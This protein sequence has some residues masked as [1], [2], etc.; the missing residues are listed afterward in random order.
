MNRREFLALA[1]AAAVTTMAKEGAAAAKAAAK[2][3][4]PFFRARP[5]LQLLGEDRFGVV[6]MTS[7][8]A[9]G[10]IEWSQDDGK[11]W[12]KVWTEED[13][14]RDANGQMHRAIVE[15]GYDPRKPLVYRVHSR[16]F[17]EFGGAHV[18]YDG[19]ETVLENRMGAVIRADGSVSFLMVND[20][21]GEAST[22]PKLMD[23]VKEPVSFTVFNGDILDGINNEDQVVRQLLGQMSLV[24]ERTQAACWYLRGNHETR[25]AYARHLRDYLALPDGHFYGATTMGDARIVFIDSG[26]DKADDH[27]EYSGLVDFDHYLQRQRR[28]LEREFASDAWK[29]AGVRIVITHIPPWFAYENNEKM[30]WRNGRAPR[31]DKFFDILNGANVTLLIAGHVHRCTYGDPFTAR[32]RFP[33]YRLFPVVAGGGWDRKAENPLNRPTL[34]RFTVKGKEVTATFVDID[35]KTVFTRTYKA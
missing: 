19:D 4:E 15:E 14:L 32:K 25:G 30:W 6:W 13:G 10:W 7:R 34:G 28:F 23:Y 9:T 17:A 5:H 12:T 22:C 16:A 11:T 33:E 1:G 31:L 8:P 35:G 29:N 27:K 20:V 24:S 26:E 21:H 3:D 2:A 18:K